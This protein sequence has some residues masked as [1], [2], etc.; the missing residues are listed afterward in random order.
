MASDEAKKGVQRALDDDQLLIFYQPI[1]ELESRRIVSAEALLRARRGNG[2]IRSGEKL[3]E[4]AEES[5]AMYALDSWLVRTAYDD[6]ARWQRTSPHV[7]ININLSPREFQEGNLVDRLDKLIAGCGTDWHRVNLEITETSYIEDPKET[8]HM[9]DELKE[10]GMQLWLDDF[11]T[12]HSS[13]E[14]VKHFPLDGLK[15]PGEFVK[16]I[17]DNER[18]CAITK[19]IIVLAHDVGLAVIA[20]GVEREEQLELLRELGA[21]Y[22]QGFLFSRPMPVGEFV[23]RLSS[24]PLLPT[25]SRSRGADRDPSS[26]SS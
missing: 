22:V 5:A 11:G 16:D 4:A 3:A 6:A 15:I 24:Q 26:R 7:H 23:T 13:I 12:G 10:R 14:H 8:M 20:E 2:E 18:S 1:H 17:P 9:L 19:S 25:D 21:D